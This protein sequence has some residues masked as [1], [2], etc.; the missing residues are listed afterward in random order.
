M[1]AWRMF[2]TFW[3]P[4]R[5]SSSTVSEGRA[6]RSIFQTETSGNKEPTFDGQPAGTEDMTQM[7]VQDPMHQRDARHNA[8]TVMTGLT[9]HRPG[10]YVFILGTRVRLII[11]HCPSRRHRDC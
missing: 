3:A 1:D 8:G 7:M 11:G 2:I 10:K 4:M 5:K 6:S 9:S